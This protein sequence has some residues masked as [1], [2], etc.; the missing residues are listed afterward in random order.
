MLYNAGWQG[1]KK[2]E[3]VDRCL[4]ETFSRWL[5]SGK[6]R[7]VV[8]RTPS[9]GVLSCY[10][11]WNDAYILW[12]NTKKLRW[13]EVFYKVEIW[14]VFSLLSSISHVKLCEVWLSRVISIAEKRKFFVS[15]DVDNMRTISYCHQISELFI[16]KETYFIYKRSSWDL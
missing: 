12:W 11:S 9:Y 7:F 8:L 16:H 15:F 6:F 10:G 1:K 5:D 3:K 4:Q 14:W 13:P 2:R